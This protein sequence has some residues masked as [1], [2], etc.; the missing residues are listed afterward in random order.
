MV[1]QTVKV[2]STAYASN[3]PSTRNLKDKIP[4][5]G[6]LKRV[7]I[8]V[9]VTFSTGATAPTY[10]TDTP[11]A[12]RVFR[13]IRFAKLLMS[14]GSEEFIFIKGKH[15][16]LFHSLLNTEQFFAD[17]AATGV[18]VA[19]AD[20]RG[21]SLIN[22][23]HLDSKNEY[24]YFDF[25]I[26]DIANVVTAGVLT[27][28]NI[29]ITIG[30][31]YYNK[32]SEF[33]QDFGVET[34][35]VDTFSV[36]TG[37]LRVIDGLTLGRTFVAEI[38]DGFSNSTFNL[39][40]FKVSDNGIVLQESS[41]FE[42]VSESYENFHSLITIAGMVSPVG[43]FQNIVAYVPENPIGIDNTTKLEVQVPTTQN[44]DFVHVFLR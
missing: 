41:Y 13:F 12:A 33:V 2:I 38:I 10:N 32:R 21:N 24:L 40:K 43:G 35:K 27:A 29:E 36:V 44:F 7:Q 31:E 28:T 14:S 4:L 9:R 22:K 16:P 37:G 34:N 8:L 6:D 5:L 18:S 1:F 23:V 19:S 3:I 42:Y 11:V 39:D 17:V 15:L 26:D 30:F 25:E 20:Y